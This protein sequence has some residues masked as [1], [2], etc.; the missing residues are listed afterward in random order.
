MPRILVDADACPVRAEIARAAKRFGIEA[1]FFSN[2]SQEGPEDDGALIV[3]V[4]DRADAADF[5]IVSECAEADLV[6][7][8]D[9]GL[10]AMALGKGASALS[11][12][13]RLFRPAEMAGLLQSRHLAKKARRAGARTRGPRAMS[14][15]DLTAFRTALTDWLKTAT[16]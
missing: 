5:A 12:R 10:A 16:A 2:S 13:G 6:V 7:T 4:S 9:I 3:R 1:L 15:S 14:K 8:D 11:S